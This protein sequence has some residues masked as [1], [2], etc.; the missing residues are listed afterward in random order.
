MPICLV[1]LL[2]SLEHEWA[3][4]VSSL[5]VVSVVRAVTE[6]KLFR[7]PTSTVGDLLWVKVLDLDEI[8][9][10]G[11]VLLDLAIDGRGLFA[12]PLGYDLSQQSQARVQSTGRQSGEQTER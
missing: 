4:V 2:F 9:D 5:L 10:L 8:N 12:P 3:D 11:V 1:L 6:R 7:L